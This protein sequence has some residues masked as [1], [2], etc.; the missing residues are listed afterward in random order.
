MPKARLLPPPRRRTEASDPFGSLGS[1]V[2]IRYKYTGGRRS[3]TSSYPCAEEEGAMRAQLIPLDG[4]PAVD[5]GKDLTVVGR[6]EDCDLR[7]DHKSVSKMHC[8]IVKT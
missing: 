7:L 5:I 6:K 1:A 8:I 2:V 3:G 4:S